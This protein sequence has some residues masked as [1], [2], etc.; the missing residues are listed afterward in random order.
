MSADKL[1]A[2]WEELDQLGA[3]VSG[4]LNLR[5]AFADDPARFERYSAALNDLFVDY[6]K[7]LITDDVMAALVR[8]AKAA[9]VEEWR[10]R[11][12]AG[13]RINITED[14]DVLHTALCNLDG[15]AVKVDGEELLIMKESDILGVIE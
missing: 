7:N 12:F 5:Q 4:K 9:N 15:G 1:T 2:N 3:E 10:D 6:S 8:L 11:M 13:D 14:R